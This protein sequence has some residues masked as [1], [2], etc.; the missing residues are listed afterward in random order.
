MLTS[1]VDRLEQKASRVD[2]LEQK[3][4]RVDRLEQK[5]AE[6]DEDRLRLMLGNQMIAFVKK[7][8]SVRKLSS[9]E[10]RQ[11]TSEH[12][13]TRLQ[14]LAETMP[15][16]HFKRHTGLKPE[17]LGIVRNLGR[18]VDQRNYAPHETYTEFARIL[19]SDRYRDSEVTMLHGPTFK[20]VYGINL[21]E[22]ALKA[23]P[24]LFTGAEA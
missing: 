12:T 14:I 15:E 21:E 5:D 8:V 20:F 9:D 1:R 6:M 2:R 13:T 19:L 17:Y 3:T 23:L 11:S 4:S 16:K 24:K 18:F 7:V 10:S 22:A